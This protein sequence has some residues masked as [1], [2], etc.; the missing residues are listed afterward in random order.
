MAVHS[1]RFRRI[2][3]PLLPVQA[4][5]IGWVWSAAVRR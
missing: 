3:R 1:E 2:P 4:L 5:L